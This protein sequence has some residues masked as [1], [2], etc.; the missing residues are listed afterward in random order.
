MVNIVESFT[1]W[2]H[3]Q[4]G[5]FTTEPNSKIPMG[6]LLMGPQIYMGIAELN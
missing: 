6:S 4:S 2:L 1:V 5:Y 3:N